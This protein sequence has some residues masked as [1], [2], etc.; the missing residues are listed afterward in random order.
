M[1]S[2]DPFKITEVGIFEATVDSML[3]SKRFALQASL[4]SPLSPPSS[5]LLFFFLND[6][7]ALDWHISLST[8]RL[9]GAGEGENDCRLKNSIVCLKRRPELPKVSR[10]L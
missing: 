9:G 3:A 5:M 6:G 8:L 4:A 10:L 1:H 2:F 7:V